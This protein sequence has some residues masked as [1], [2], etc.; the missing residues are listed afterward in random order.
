M[1]TLETEL[2]SELDVDPIELQRIRLNQETARIPWSEL[3]RFFAQGY[4]IWVHDDLDLV[5]MALRF[6]LDDAAA[7]EAEMTRG[8]LSR[9][10]DDQARGWFESQ[11]SLWAVVVKP[12]ILVQETRCTSGSTQTPAQG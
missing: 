8:T 6:T 12:W 9:V 2:A 5:E 1:S 10:S 3:Q 4:L 7:I 11:S